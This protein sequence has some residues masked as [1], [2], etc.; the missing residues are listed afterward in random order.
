LKRFKHI[1]AE[2]PFFKERAR[3]SNPL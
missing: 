2:F 1:H 3:I